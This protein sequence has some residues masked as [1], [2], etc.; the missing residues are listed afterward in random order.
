[1]NPFDTIRKNI[2]FLKH[3]NADEADFFF[4]SGRII[5][6]KK[7][8]YAELK[9]SSSLNIVISGIF[10]VETIGN[11][12]VV[13][14]TSGSFFGFLP[15]IENRKRGNIRALLDSTIFVIQEED[16]YRF[17]LKYHKALR[18]YI[19]MIT[20]LGFDINETG[21]KYFD[22]KGRVISV[23]GQKSGSGKSYLASSLGLALS[24]EDTVLLDLSYSG[25]SL[26]DILG[27]ERTAPISEKDS[28]AGRAES[29]INGNLLHVK[30]NL[31]VLNISFSSRV[32]TDA[33]I[34]GLVLFLLSRR[35]RYII[36]DISNSDAE[37]R[38]A[39]FAGSDMIFAMTGG[40]KDTAELNLLFDEKIND[41]QRIFYVKNNY[42]SREEGTFTGG[43]ILEKND[44]FLSSRSVDS[45][46]NYITAGRLAP[47][48]EKITKNEKA[49]VVQSLSC[50]SI[51]LGQFFIDL[52]E[53]GKIFDCIYSSCHSFF[54]SALYLLGTDVKTV[55]GT[56]RKFYSPDHMNRIM[57]IAFPEK[58]VFKNG[59]ILRYA[60]EIA[61]N[62][63][64]EMFHSMPVCRLDSPEGSRVFS[65]G[66]LAR[67]MAASCTVSPYF[68]P[69]MIGRGEFSSGYPSARVS[70]AE[71]FRTDYDDIYYLSINNRDKL[72]ANDEMNEFY[73]NSLTPDDRVY[74][75]ESYYLQAGKNLHIELSESE[76]KFDKIADKTKRLSESLVVRIL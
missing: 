37:L 36:A 72:V 54:L 73:F 60:T 63:R 8:Q 19:R 68:E 33:S 22:L 17:F 45:I 57:E 41:F 76:F 48:I 10:E 28:E 50:D 34:I 65:T 31:Y 67:I 24:G 9:K 75:D 6:V 14:F 69:V 52:Q 5:S 2:P 32:R 15:F 49:L 51:C 1:M 12:E 25:T 13:Y 47:F 26:S 62:R 16:L 18:G 53:S 71:L 7:G 30:D 3:L 20:S 64:A 29:A 35:F 21:R 40:K 4:R 58:Y 39:M 46:M 56:I 11:A 61:G 38:D 59:K 44:G 74:T 70:P 27:M 55:T 43:L 66:S 23:F 42:S